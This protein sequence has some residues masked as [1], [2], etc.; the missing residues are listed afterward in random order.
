MLT[1]GRLWCQSLLCNDVLI[2]RSRQRVSG[3]RVALIVVIGH[4]CPPVCPPPA[5][6]LLLPPALVD[7]EMSPFQ[8]Y[9]SVPQFRCLLPTSPH[10]FSV[11]I[12][13][14]HHISWA[15]HKNCCQQPHELLVCLNNFN[16]TKWTHHCPWC[17][18]E[19]YVLGWGVLMP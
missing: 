1:Q 5:W 11:N 3:Q 9:F 19:A 10:S 4:N 7:C 16:K 17:G 18:D 15:L 12:A 13:L 6:L 2:L 8:I 14:D